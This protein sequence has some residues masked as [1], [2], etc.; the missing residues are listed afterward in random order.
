MQDEACMHTS[1][2]RPGNGERALEEPGS[3]PL[4][5][6]SRASSNHIADNFL[7]KLVATKK[8]RRRSLA[9]PS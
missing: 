2:S 7:T 6:R 9:L 8:A 1:V 4:L 3:Y 5:F